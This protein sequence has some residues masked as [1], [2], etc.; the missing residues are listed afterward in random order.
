MTTTAQ[1]FA[2]YPDGHEHAGAEITRPAFCRGCGARFTQS[3]FSEEVLEIFE[4][5]R[6]LDQIARELPGLWAPAECPRCERLGIRVMA[7]VAGRR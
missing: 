2:V 5:A 4:A 1:M 6:A 3:M 7:T